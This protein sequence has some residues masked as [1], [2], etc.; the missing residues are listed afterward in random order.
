[1]RLAVPITA[2]GKICSHFGRCD[3]VWLAELDQESGALCRP[4]QVQRPETKC[5]ELA[6]WI[7][8]LAVDL[9][10]TPGIGTMA[11]E[12]LLELGTQVVTG[13]AAATPE[14]MVESYLSNPAGNSN[15]CTPTEHRFR[16]C[17]E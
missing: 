3:G 11:R 10:L 2:S 4:R 13:L 8:S 7:R 15:A 14:T 5:D 1:M 9:V 6:D 16:H 12:R 17:A